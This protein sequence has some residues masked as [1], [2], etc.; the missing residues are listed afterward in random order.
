MTV[1]RLL[2]IGMFL[3]LTTFVAASNPTDLLLRITFDQAIADSSFY[4]T[5]VTNTKVTLVADRFG[6][7]D[8]A[9]SFSSGSFLTLGNR[10]LY[11]LNTMTI[12]FWMKPTDLYREQVIIN[13][14]EWHASYKVSLKSG[15]ICFW[16]GD[17]T[18]WYTLEYPFPAGTAWTHVAVTYTGAT[19]ALYLNGV[20]VF[21]KNIGK[22]IGNSSTPVELGRNTWNK[23]E[24]YAGY[25]D[26]LCI[27]NRALL[28]LE[29]QT[30]HIG[31]EVFAQAREA[32][33]KEV[34]IEQKKFRPLISM[35]MG[36]DYSGCSLDITSDKG[37]AQSKNENAN[38]IRYD[39]E[40]FHQLSGNMALGFNGLRLL[41]YKFTRPL[42][43][44]PMQKEMYSFN[45]QSSTGLERYTWGIS[46]LP[47]ATQFIDNK[48]LRTLL[49]YRMQSTKQRYIT[50]GIIQTDVDFNESNNNIVAL[51]NGDRVNFRSDY[52]D[53]EISIALAKI[54]IKTTNS[55]FG[56]EYVAEN[57]WILRCGWFNE[58]WNR[59]SEMVYQTGLPDVFP[60]KYRN[61][62]VVLN[63][64]TENQTANGFNGDILMRFGWSDVEGPI[65]WN[66]Y[67]GNN[68]SVGMT[69]MTL[70]A[71][72]WYN[73]NLSGKKHHNLLIT[74]GTNLKYHFQIIS[75]ESNSIETTNKADAGGIILRDTDLL[76]RIN[77][78]ASYRY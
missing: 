51:H 74:L 23:S 32:Y 45:T 30:L 39:T 54:P 75:L 15:K 46:L 33:E 28:D 48:L 24:H 20:K 5:P 38:V 11:N 35:Q 66:N 76:F 68:Q 36:Y 71:G 59:I 17:R 6:K 26:D 70:G 8:A 72:M 55:V 4:N 9:G 42:T 61:S 13:K 50:K 62:G 77:L 34:A 21:T 2:Y 63:Y 57:F 14:D 43:N 22:P 73:I 67:A 44:S 16:V 56:T 37:E 40:S 60:I 18:D 3:M 7:P 49:S 10:D 58:E 41:D 29:I 64:E 78:L 47:L 31:Y 12:A 65:N 52:L 19:Q 53:R 27:Y 69:S 25:L 1:Q